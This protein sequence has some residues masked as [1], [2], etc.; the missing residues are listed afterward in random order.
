MEMLI[1]KHFSMVKIW[2][3]HHPTQRVATK[4]FL[5]FQVPGGVS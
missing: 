2:G 3:S 1:S 5:A 4:N